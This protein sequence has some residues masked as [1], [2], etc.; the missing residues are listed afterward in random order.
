MTAD[1]PLADAAARER[2]RTE[3]GTTLF[4]E[5]GAGTGATT[6]LIERIVHMV[7]YGFLP[8][9]SHL[10]ANVHRERRR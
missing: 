2:I 8:D 9:F 1:T 7:A 4:V 5:A 6:S 10:A 3:H